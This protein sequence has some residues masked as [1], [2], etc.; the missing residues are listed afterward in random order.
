[1]DSWLDSSS[2]I[3]QRSGDSMTPSTETRVD[4]MSLRIV[5]FLLCC[6]MTSRC[7]PSRARGHRRNSSAAHEL[8]RRLAP[9]LLVSRG[10]VR[11]D[12]R[13]LREHRL[14]LAAV[15]ELPAELLDGRE[16]GQWTLFA[17][18]LGDVH[19]AHTVLE[20]EDRVAQVRGGRA[21]QLL[22]RRADQFLVAFHMV[23]LQP[24][25]NQCSSH[26]LPFLSGRA[27]L[28]RPFPLEIRGALRIH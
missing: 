12:L 26:R 3:A 22:K 18:G 5:V 14:L 11:R 17:F 1:M 20:L 23:G 21:V 24:V 27:A 15:G 16:A 9:Q 25:A 13:E 4:S 7:R 10:A 19:E 28:E 2:K 6:L 8:P